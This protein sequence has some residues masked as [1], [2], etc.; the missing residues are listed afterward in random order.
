MRRV[1]HLSI[2]QVNAALSPGWGEP[3]GLDVQTL[4]PRDG[5]F[6]P[7]ADGLVIDLDHLGLTPL[8]HAEFVRRLILTVL[9]Y[10]VAVHGYN[11]EVEQIEAL[12]A[13]GVLVF[14]RPGPDLFARLAG[15]IEA[16]RDGDAAA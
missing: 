15:A 1:F 7:D 12:E 8:E 13:K 10:P 5:A 2:D 6:P 3:A 11:L 4:F 16:R 9:P 14:R